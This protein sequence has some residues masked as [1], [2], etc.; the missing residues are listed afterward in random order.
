MA[1]AYVGDIGTA[2]EVNTFIDLTGATVKE[3]IIKKPSG[4][5][6]TKTAAIPEGLTDSDGKI[7]IFTVA[8]DFDEAGKY[9]VQPHIESASTDHLGNTSNFTVYNV[10]DGN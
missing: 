8:G 10:F 1:K 4:T 7:V 9:H 2:I 5:I 6:L 3:I